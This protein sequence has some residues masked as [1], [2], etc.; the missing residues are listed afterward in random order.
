MAS[1]GTSLITHC[2]LN[3]I[4]LLLRAST[5]ILKNIPKDTSTVC[6]LAGAKG[7]PSVL[8]LAGRER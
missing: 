7:W 4:S 5:Y 2:N 6:I 1:L 8:C 3:T